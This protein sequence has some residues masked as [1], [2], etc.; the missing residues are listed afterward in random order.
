MYN[1]I[2]VI[3]NGMKTSAWEIFIGCWEYEEER[4][5]PFEPFSKLKTTFCRC[6]TSIK[7]KIGMTCV[8]R[9]HEVKIKWYRS[10]DSSSKWSFYWVMTWQ[11]LFSGR[12]NLWWGS[13]VFQIAL[14]SRRILSPLG[15]MVNFSGWGFFYRVVGI[16]GRVILTILAMHIVKS[17]IL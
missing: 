13:R 6:W 12:I 1:N 4:F 3:Y 17:N 10:N 7:I 16:W 5:W 14:R 9:E 11:L 15:G 8:Y 2:F